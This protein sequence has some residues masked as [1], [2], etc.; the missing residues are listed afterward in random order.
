MIM[1][2][3][4]LWRS[5]RWLTAGSVT[6]AS[7]RDMAR[8]GA[9]PH[10]AGVSLPSTARRRGRSL[11][12]GGLRR[13]PRRSGTGPRAGAEELLATA[14]R[15]LFVRVFAERGAAK[16]W[17]GA[18]A[19]SPGCGWRSTPTRP[20]C[21][22]VPWEL[23]RNPD[24]DQPVVLAAS[25][26]VLHVILGSRRASAVWSAPSTNDHS[27]PTIRPRREESKTT[28]DAEPVRVCDRLS[29]TPPA[30]NTLNPDGRPHSSTSH[31]PPVSAPH[32][33]PSFG[34]RY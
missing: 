31:P 17:A 15:Q 32:I 10:E 4:R 21:P 33:V 22:G 19:T 18:E 8:R 16:L 34:A 29:I 11:V 9:A 14:G 28:T 26:F 5:C 30:G 3:R 27:P 1:K 25:E 23:L 2:R 20:T 12:P 7:Q 13:V 6:G 24:T